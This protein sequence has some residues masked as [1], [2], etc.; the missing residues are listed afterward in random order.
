M[1]RDLRPEI[2][3]ALE[4]LRRRIRRYVLIEGI[5]AI[6]ALLGGLFWLSLTADMIWFQLSKLELPLWFR[7]GFT[8]LA[9]GVCGAA[10]TTWLLFRWLRSFRARALALVLERRFPE[11]D[12]RL[13]TAV[14]L[15][16]SSRIERSGLAGA[17]L[18][19]TVAEA[20]QTLARLDLR[21]VFDPRPLRR[22]VLAAAVLL[23]SI[24][25]FGVANAEA[26]RRWFDAYVVGRENY[27]DPYR[28][29]ELSVQIIAQ[30]GDRLREF[31][32]EGRY[33]H[34]R[35]GDLTVLVTV[36]PGKRVPETVTLR[37]RS[38]G[39]T[40]TTRGAVSMSRI[41]ERQFRHTIARVV[42]P[43][44]LWIVGGD[45]TNRTPLRVEIVPPPK[46]D[47]MELD[48]R[49]PP[50]TGLEN[51]PLLVQ[52]ARVS[53]PMETQFVLRARA[54]KP[55][56]GVQLRS[57]RFHLETA[58]ARAPTDS[59]AATECRLTLTG[60]QGT[61]TRR[62]DLPP[63]I[64]ER[65]LPGDRRTFLFPL[66]V[67][68]S[69]EQ[70]LQSLWEAA[71]EGR[72]VE[73]PTPFPLPPDQPLQLYLQD[74]DDIL[75]FDPVTVTING[76]P[77]LPPVVD[78]RLKGIGNRITRLATI[79]LAGR[80]TDD[81]GVAA[82][83]FVS[84]VNGVEEPR[85]APLARP[86]QGERE[87]ELRRTPQEPVERFDVTPLQLEPGRQLTLAL[88]ARDAD[89]L[90]GPHEAAGSVF[91]FEIVTDEALLGDLYD[92]E[93]NLRLR[94]EHIREEVE[95]VRT[96]LLLHR[97]RYTEGERL[98]GLRPE[99]RPAAEVAEE[100]RQ[101][102]IAVQACADRSLH[103]IRKNHA[104]TREVEARFRDIREEL[105]NN[106][107]DTQA[108][109]A[110]L[111]EGIISPLSDLNQTGYPSADEMIGLFALTLERQQDPTAVIDDAVG[112]LDRMIA[113]M[114]RILEQMRQRK[115]FHEVIQELQALLERQRALLEATERERQRSVIEDLFR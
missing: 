51:R 83:W 65:L 33:K 11:L 25:G 4:T 12:D 67:S 105:V 46:I 92:K 37:H 100:L 28:Q 103:L 23:T 108:A 45:F 35:G 89:D 56:S 21:E 87:F 77:D 31:D 94:F 3:A 10:L 44:E 98:K 79:P 24:L 38:H 47:P 101:I 5:A 63:Q 71:A 93:M 85:T 95:A 7:W 61:E 88:H 86:P 48:P 81:Y 50:Y 74:E 115:G 84:Q 104:E 68:A 73:L 91:G 29:S 26:L 18:E 14:E 82:A 19:R 69:A 62:F 36:R 13:V 41:G 72:E 39:P 99:E 107:L 34:P 57:E 90:N 40:G 80:I 70:A 49:Y 52:G 106:R 15:A 32:A 30:P 76:V 20:A 58:L 17:M 96:D 97:G 42:E 8:T 112:I 6:L 16:E 78:V 53:L 114:D 1:D 22:A 64:A 2:A 111:D 55:L 110:R 60:P 113:Q 43:H 102:G 75:S 66:H 9:G 59:S 27:W 109:L 54:N